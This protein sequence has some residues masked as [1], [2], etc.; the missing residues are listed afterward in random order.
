MKERSLF[1]QVFE[2]GGCDQAERVV[3]DD[4]WQIRESE[5]EPVKE[6]YILQ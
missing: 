1:F 3:L 5:G 6:T 4:V 2:G